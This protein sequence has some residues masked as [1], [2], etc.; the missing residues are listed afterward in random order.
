[1]NM[2][3][4]YVFKDE[5][6]YVLLDEFSDYLQTLNFAAHTINSYNKDLKEYFNFLESKNILLDNADHYSVRDYLTFLKSKSLTNSTMSR[7][8]SSIKKFYKYLIRNGL[9]DKTRIVDMKSPKREEHIAKFLSL[10]D[11]DRI[12][13]IDDDG[14]FTLL[15][16]KMMALFMYAIGLRVSELASLRLSMIKKGDETLRICGKGSKVRDIPVLPI[17]YENWDTYMEKRRMI[18]KEYS[19]NN[20]YLFIN[21]FG[22]PISDRS[23]RTSMKRL[24]RNAN[25]SMDFSPHTLRHTFA[26][27]LL[28]NDAEIRGVQELLGHETI[29]TTQRYTHVTNS[30][31]FEVYNKFHP[32]SN[33]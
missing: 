1:M 20:D 31:L 29:A 7:H 21:R 22:K 24:I 16:D 25:I 11:I 18:Q 10:D 33:N 8:L 5:K 12:L 27:H 28:N 30:R 26:T 6:V 14:D 4:D 15:R 17:V 2:H 32:H 13:A 3:T 9:S 19:Q 23:I